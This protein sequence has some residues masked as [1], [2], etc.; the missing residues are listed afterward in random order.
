MNMQAT[1][2]HRVRHVASRIVWRSYALGCVVG[3]FTGIGYVFFFRNESAV[4][5]AISYSTVTRGTI[6]TTVKATG[7]VAFANEQQLRFNQKG[8]VTNVAVRA[9]D[10]VKKGQL[11]AQLDTSAIQADIRQAQLSLH[12]TSLQLQQLQGSKEKALLDAE[13]ALRESERQFANARNALEVARSKLP[14]DVASAKR[15]VQERE[16]AVAQAQAALVQAQV[17]TLQDLGS[18][19]QSIL[20]RSED[21]L[22]TLYAILVQRPDAQRG[23]ETGMIE[24]FYRL[25]N[26]YGLKNETERAYGEANRAVEEMRHTYGGT[27][28]TVRETEVLASAIDDARTVAHGLSVLADAMYRLVQGAVDDSV[29]FTLQD[30]AAIKQTIIAARTTTAGLMTEAE[31]AQASLTGGED[32]VTSIVIQ[33]KRDALASAHNALLAAQEHLN[34]LQTQTPGDLQQQEDALMRV[35]EDFQSKQ[36]ARKQTESNADVDVRLRQNDIAQ[37]ATSLLKTQTILEEYRLIAPFDGVIRRLDYQV[38]DN[39]L[40]SGEEKFVVLENPET[41]IV[42]IL[43]DQVDIVRVRKEMAA[44]VEF[45][46]LPTLPLQGVIDDIDST[47][48]ETSGVVSYEVSIRLPTPADLTILSGMTAT[49][50]IETARRENVLVVP[51]LALL[52]RND[53]TIVRM[54]DGSTLVV[55]TGATDGRVTEVVSGL[56]EGD[57]VLSMNIDSS[58]TTETNMNGAAQ[59]LRMGGAGGP[60]GGREFRGTVGR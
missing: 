12:A 16:A 33:Q 43:L 6:V 60:P 35:Q 47:P 32:G 46:A 53:R 41:L 18:T 3:L 26:D 59:M 8:K 50:Q 19:A 40:D 51:N 2:Y 28:S 10:R 39:L 38:G 57:S 42:T 56:R 15:A 37:K 7:N 17:T 23:S 48:V 54:A 58:P 27:L 55:E 14:S 5:T 29:D 21:L 9:G 4:D 25:Y 20:T 11:I 34:V 30:I 36:L 45:D 44:Q 22:D 1:V 13:N 24:I 31:N 52:R 49:V